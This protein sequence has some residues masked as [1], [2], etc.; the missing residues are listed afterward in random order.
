MKPMLKVVTAIVIIIL[1]LAWY[2]RPIHV[3]VNGHSKMISK[4][5]LGIVSQSPAKECNCPPPKGPGDLE[6][7]Y[8]KTTYHIYKDQS[9]V[10][11]KKNKD[12]VLYEIS[13][14]ELKKVVKEVE[15]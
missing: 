13:D 7:T 12:Y 15:P 4:Q 5:V 2:E 10:Y 14:D 6:I 9:K 1:L 11:Y 3:K 8:K